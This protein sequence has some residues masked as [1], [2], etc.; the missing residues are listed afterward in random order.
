MLSLFRL[1]SFQSYFKHHVNIVFLSE[2][3][4][5]LEPNSI[6]KILSR[7]WCDQHVP[8][9]SVIYARDTAQNYTVHT[10]PALFPHFL[11]IRPMKKKVKKIWLPTYMPTDISFVVRPRREQTGF[12]AKLLAERFHKL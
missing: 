6:T 11:C 9:I 12:T 3:V 1:Q 5:K 8:H 10:I 4:N 7:A 2:H